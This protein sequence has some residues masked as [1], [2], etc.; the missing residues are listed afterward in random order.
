MVQSPGGGLRPQPLAP[1]KSVPEL[2]AI[3]VRAQGTQLEIMGPLKS[4]G[5]PAWSATPV[6]VRFNLKTFE[7]KYTGLRGN[8]E[9]SQDA[10]MFRRLAELVNFKGSPPDERCGL[11]RQ[12]LFPFP[13]LGLKVC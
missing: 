8:Q 9:V 12:V 2:M 3:L 6:A 10:H 11:S 13:V 4:T 1:T 7:I 5:K